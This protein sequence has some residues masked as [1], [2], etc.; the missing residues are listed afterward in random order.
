MNL[1][2]YRKSFLNYLKA[3]GKDVILKSQGYGDYEIDPTIPT[4]T[5]DQILKR[6]ESFLP[7]YYPKMKEAIR[8]N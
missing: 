6:V 1:G 7:Q 8:I 3:T 5:P 4:F 2:D